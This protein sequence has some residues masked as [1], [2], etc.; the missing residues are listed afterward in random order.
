MAGWAGLGWGGG[1]GEKIAD[2]ETSIGTDKRLFLSPW[3]FFQEGE[4][5]QTLQV[6]HI[7]MIANA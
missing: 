7:L 1:S 2:C 4:T 3:F 6:K 5:Q